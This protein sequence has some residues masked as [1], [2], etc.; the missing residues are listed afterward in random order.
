MQV[1]LDRLNF[2]ADV[3]KF[4]QRDAFI[5]EGVLVTKV[6]WST[7][8]QHKS[9]LNNKLFP[10]ADRIGA[11]SLV[12]HITFDRPFKRA[13]SNGVVAYNPRGGKIFGSR[14]TLCDFMAK[15]CSND[16]NTPLSHYF[17][18]NH[19]GFYWESYHP[20]QLYMHPYM[21]IDIKTVVGGDCKFNDV[22]K[23]VWE[24]IKLMEEAIKK[25]TLLTEVLCLVLMNNRQL[26]ANTT[27]WSFHL[28]W[29]Q[30]IVASMTELATLVLSVGNRVP[31]QPNGQP[32]LDTK[33][34]SNQN[35]LFRMPFCGKMGDDTSALVPI[36]PYKDNEATGWKY[37]A[38]TRDMS[39]VFVGRGSQ[40][41]EAWRAG[42]DA[43]R[44][45]TW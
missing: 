35:Q 8:K 38:C 33:P 41:R 44:T 11:T 28:H 34:Y 43:A 1:V 5:R 4:M 30:I 14:A 32:L 39:T 45:G 24:A 19:I 7:E 18:P 27:K 42:T 36:L 9:Y 40:D 15:V 25:G 37:R 31:T 10:V 26:N 3:L 13:N 17:N 16:S 12:R 23:P 20:Q 22:F 2:N 6:A 29:P 21:D